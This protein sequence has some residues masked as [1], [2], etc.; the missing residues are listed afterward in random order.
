MVIAELRNITKV[1]GKAGAKVEALRGINLE[2]QKGEFIAIM[3]A[4]GS[5]KSTLLN[6]LGCLDKATGGEYIL[7]NL[8]INSYSNRKLAKIRN[9]T[10]GFVV[11]YFGLLDDY[12]VYEN[13]N[14][15]LEYGRAPRRE[16]KKLIYSVLEKLGIENKVKATPKQLS[17]GQNQRVAIARAIVNNPD[18]ILADEPTGALD[19]KTGAEV[20]Q[21]FKKLNEDGKTVIIV[22]HDEKIAQQCKRIINIEDGKIISDKT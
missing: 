4:S 1:Y 6:I 9:K 22:T 20:M 16:R 8:N 21:L 5:G 13:V 3:G 11:Q 18:I 7:N 10:F 19:K 12:N 14:V 15:P 17:G 2:I